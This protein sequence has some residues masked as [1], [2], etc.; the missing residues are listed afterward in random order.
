MLELPSLRIEASPDAGPT[1]WLIQEVNSRR[2]LG[3]ARQRLSPSRPWLRWLSWP[4]LEICETAD[5]SLLFTVDRYWGLQSTW[6][7]RDAEEHHV[8]HL[9]GQSAWDCYGRLLA[10]L[11]PA[12][13]F[14]RRWLSP[15]GQ[16][17]ASV[18]LGDDA[19]V[20]S[21]ACEDN[22]FMRMILLASVL[23]K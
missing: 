9:R 3:L 4:T 18:Q 8:G 19:A 2:P 23:R 7:I 12:G 21:F 22:P 14:R 5:E 16:E 11:E 17:L 20:L 13:Q 6:I 1:R 15:D 10:Q